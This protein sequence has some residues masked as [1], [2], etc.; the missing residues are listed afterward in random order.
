MADQGSSSMS[1]TRALLLLRD[2][3]DL[4]VRFWVGVLLLR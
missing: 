3:V 2:F 1:S 4:W